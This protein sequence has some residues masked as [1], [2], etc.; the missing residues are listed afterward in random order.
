MER[1]YETNCECNPKN[2][3]KGIVCDVSHCA[4]HDGEHECYAGQICVG[5]KDA[6]TSKNTVCATF[7][8]KEY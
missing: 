7:K 2:H 5:P 4:F 1:K 6:T 8:P 3:I